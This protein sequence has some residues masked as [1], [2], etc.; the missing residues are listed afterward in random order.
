MKKLI[1]T[2]AI[3]ACGLWLAASAQARN[4]IIENGPDGHPVVISEANISM[5]EIPDIGGLPN[6]RFFYGTI[7]EIP[8]GVNVR[9]GRVEAYGR[10]AEHEGNSNYV[11]YV[12][13]G[14]GSLVNTDG[15]GNEVSRF[16]F[17]PGDVITFR[18]YTMHYWEVG[19]E[20]WEFLGVEQAAA[21]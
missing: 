12:L 1:K 14:T 20:A 21:Q 18:P 9:F 17:K 5:T 3:A 16:E 11:L 2:A 10:I 4:V 7:G 6:D 8:T 19:P 13:K 15:E